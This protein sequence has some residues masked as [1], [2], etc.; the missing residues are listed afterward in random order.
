MAPVQAP[1]GDAADSPYLAAIADRVVV[2]DG[3]AGTW[4]QE[5]DLTMED[6]GTPELEGC[7]EILVETRPELIKKMHA[8]YLDAGADVIE[9][10]TFG[11]MQATLA[12]YGLGDRAVELHRIAASPA[13]QVADPVVANARGAALIAAIGVGALDWDEVPSRVGIAATYTPDPAAG[14]VHDR[15]YLAFRDIYRRTHGLYA[16]HNAGRLGDV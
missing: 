9:T 11:G 5:Q 14:E 15:Q 10:N 3:A 13:R 4:L 7:P 12:E 8:E 1:R 16:R 6:Y 2:Y